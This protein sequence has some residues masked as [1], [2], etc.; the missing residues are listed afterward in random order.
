VP[1][2]LGRWFPL[3]EPLA[4][5]VAFTKSASGKGHSVDEK[6]ESML[7][8][9]AG[10][11]SG[12]ILVAVQRLAAAREAERP[13]TE[14][15]VEIPQ[16]GVSLVDS[17]PRELFYLSVLNITASASLS[18]SLRS[19]DLSIYR[20][21]LDNQTRTA[22]YPVV[23]SEGNLQRDTHFVSF[24]V[25]QR[26]SEDLPVMVFPLASLQVHT[27]DVK[28][29]EE[30]IWQ[31]LKFVNEFQTKPKKS[32]GDTISD[33]DDED[34]S[35][36][37]DAESTVRGS[38]ARSEAEPP[39][40]KADG[41]VTRSTDDIMHSYPSSSSRFY[42]GLLQ[43]DVKGAIVTFDA[44]PAARQKSAGLTVNPIAIVLNAGSAALAHID[45]APVSL[46]PFVLEN[47][48]GN[49]H[50]LLQPVVRHFTRQLIQKIYILLGSASFLGNPVGLA[51]DVG[52][53]FKDLGRGLFSVR[54]DGVGGIF[55]GT[56]AAAGGVV[57]GV[58]GAVGNVVS[59]AGSA[60]S[61]LMDTDYQ[62]RRQAMM[63]GSGG[64]SVTS[65]IKSG[66]S[67]V[68]EGLSGIVLDP[69]KGAKA[70]GVTGFAKG[71][72]KGL[73]G[74]VV[75]STVGVVDITSSALH[76]IRSAARPERYVNI[77]RFRLPR[78]IPPD[79][80]L[81]PFDPIAALGQWILKETAIKDKIV[82]KEVKD[83]EQFLFHMA[84]LPPP[85]PPQNQPS[86]PSSAATDSVGAPAGL[87]QSVDTSASALVVSNLRLV[88]RMDLEASTELSAVQLRASVVD[89][90][91]PGAKAIQN[92]KE[93]LIQQDKKKKKRKFELFPRSN[94][95]FE[96]LNVFVTGV[97]QDGRF[98]R[99]YAAYPQSMKQAPPE[100]YVIHTPSAEAAQLATMRLMHFFSNTFVASAIHGYKNRVDD[101]TAILYKM[102]TRNGRIAWSGVNES[103]LEQ[104]EQAPPPPS[105]HAET[106]GPTFYNTLFG[107]PAP[108]K[109]KTLTVEFVR[110]FKRQ[111]K[112]FQE[113]ESIIL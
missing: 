11:V 7:R 29:G 4:A 60:L 19:A 10:V 40:Q 59:S 101:V 28:V 45:Q 71:I 113:D 52:G 25:R 58:A 68:A 17:K 106:I 73:V 31:M 51:R 81:V 21:Q 48:F 54:R 23:I 100:G 5:P 86:K 41:L 33:L 96:V 104:L 14:A 43:L 8:V 6:A 72:G 97:S 53:G 103:S 20:L 2:F 111:T 75:K 16:V 3:E 77:N 95:D 108:R 83:M 74:A 32:A 70:G 26:T 107:D 44:N 47:A 92:E 105:L 42:F 90:K 38:D 61:S 102:L 110:D 57:G 93:I 63:R 88:Y 99:I 9:R 69:F 62:M 37:T 12:S 112:I 79:H 46:S 78:Y 30:I 50:T 39:E 84:F 49:T 1:L 89:N 13:R 66:V 34:D 15:Y 67:G 36:Q 64:N 80:R 27:L 22:L 109:R 91:D 87:P 56:R 82:S 18:D 24:S 85:P 76:G 35:T 94:Q 55:R 98:V 65:G